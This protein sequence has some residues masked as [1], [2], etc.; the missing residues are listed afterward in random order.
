MKNNQLICTFRILAVSILLMIVAGCA[1]TK[2]VESNSSKNH[3]QYVVKTVRDTMKLMMIHHDSIY[4]RDSIIIHSK[5]DTVY[6]DHYKTIYKVKVDTIHS[7]HLANQ[8]DT[9]IIRDSIKTPVYVEKTLTKWQKVK[10][11]TGGFTLALIGIAIL[12]GIGYFYIKINK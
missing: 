4:V 6:L 12:V 8:T 7:L 9:M 11:K 1:T 2:K 5:G 10:Q 3:T